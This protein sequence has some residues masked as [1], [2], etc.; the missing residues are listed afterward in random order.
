M[1]SYEKYDTNAYTI[2]NNYEKRFPL[3]LEKTTKKKTKTF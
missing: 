3:L 2:I 1:L